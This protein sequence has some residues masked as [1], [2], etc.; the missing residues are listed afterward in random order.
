MKGGGDQS[1]WRE[2][3]RKQ[4]TEGIRGWFKDTYVYADFYS[5]LGLYEFFLS[6][7]SP[8]GKLCPFKAYG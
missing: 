6:C 3:K 4:E 2:E 1:L 7:Y 8:C 5:V